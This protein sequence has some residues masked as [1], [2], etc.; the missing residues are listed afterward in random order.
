MA[1]RARCPKSRERSCRTASDSSI[2]RQRLDESQFKQSVVRADTVPR[3]GEGLWPLARFFRFWTFPSGQA[4]I[5]EST[6]EGR[7]P[8]ARV[9]VLRR[10]VR[11][12][13]YCRSGGHSEKS[14]IAPA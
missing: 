4:S 9:F 3:K 8:L 7:W 10:S 14:K 1:D 6:G 13:Q 2:T 12:G 11:T 5:E